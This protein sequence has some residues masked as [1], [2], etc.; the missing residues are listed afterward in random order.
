MKWERTFFGGCSSTSGTPPTKGRRSA[1]I[2]IPYSSD[3]AKE[4][5]EKEEEDV[6]K[7]IA[8]YMFVSAAVAVA[9]FALSACGG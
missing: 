5:V 1:V 8:K 2:G 6:M 4:T 9:A 7:S 3:A